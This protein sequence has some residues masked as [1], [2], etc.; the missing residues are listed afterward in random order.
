MTLSDSDINAIAIRVAEILR[1]ESQ[2]K[3]LSMEE[4]AEFMK[5]NAEPGS[6]PAI[7]SR[8]ANRKTFKSPLVAYKVGRKRVYKKEDLLKFME[9][10]RRN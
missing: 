3:V 7:F 5:I 8:F 10:K 1:E 9:N 2:G 6:L 4:A